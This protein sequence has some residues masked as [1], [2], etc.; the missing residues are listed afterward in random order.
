VAEADAEGDRSALLERFRQSGLSIDR[1][2]RFW[3]EGAPVEH[4]GLRRAL[5]RWLDRLPPPDGRHILRLDEQRY[6]YIDVADTPLVATSLRW[7]EGTAWL[8]LTDGSE[9]AL[10]PTT[11]TLDEDGVLR[12]AVRGGKLRARLATSAAATLGEQIEST[13]DGPALRTGAGLIL[14]SRV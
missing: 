13:P 12:G 8:G 14:I 11:L 4:G 5:F 2:G 9:E 10:D 3:H 6:V 1:D 7:S